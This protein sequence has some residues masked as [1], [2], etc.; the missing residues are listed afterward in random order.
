MQNE[1]ERA[2]NPQIASNWSRSFDIL[3]DAYKQ[4][5]ENFPLLLQYRS[6]FA[7]NNHMKK[8]LIWIYEDILK[9]HLRAWRV[10]AQPGKQLL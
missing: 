9:F 5:A 3:L 10:F 4:I 6:M 2:D 7:E 8:V 1:R